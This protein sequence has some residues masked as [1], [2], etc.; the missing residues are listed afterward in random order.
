MG[1]DWKPKTFATREEYER[2]ARKRRE[3][4][5]VGSISR[6]REFGS[7]L[8]IGGVG[9]RERRRGAVGREGVCSGCVV[10]V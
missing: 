2:A 7:R 4:R 9:E 8:A 10:D 3:K 1:L 6:G 5:K